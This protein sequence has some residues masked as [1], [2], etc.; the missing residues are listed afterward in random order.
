M[1][2]PHVVKLLMWR[3]CHDDLATKVD[4]LSRKLTEDPLCPLCGV[5]AETIEN[6]LWGCP[7]AKATWNMCG[8]KIQKSWI[9]HEEFVFIVEEF[10][11]HLDNNDV[12]LIAVV[13]RNL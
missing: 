12:E 4:L 2:T 7:A 9:E 1:N 3:A 5:E 8:K 13:A 6:V 11:R 10:H